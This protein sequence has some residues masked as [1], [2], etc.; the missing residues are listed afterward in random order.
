LHWLIKKKEWVHT[1]TREVAEKMKRN[2]NWAWM[3]IWSK[4]SSDTVGGEK[5]EGEK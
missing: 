4:N 1:H 5:M 3:E 2:G